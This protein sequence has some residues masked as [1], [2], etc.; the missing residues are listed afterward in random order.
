MQ[1]QQQQ[2]GA[3][4]AGQDEQQLQLPKRLYSLLISTLKGLLLSNG[5]TATG[6]IRL[7]LAAVDVS[8]LVVGI[9][10]AAGASSSSSS[11]GA[12]AAP[13]SAQLVA[14]WMALAARCVTTAIEMHMSLHGVDA[15]A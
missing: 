8:E 11:R 2:G 3:S 13:L 14:P 10:S 15:M 12:A 4:A 5:D 6:D 9:C 1:Q 7:M